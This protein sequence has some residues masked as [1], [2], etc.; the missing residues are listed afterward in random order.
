MRGK[1]LVLFLIA[2]FCGFGLTAKEKINS[3]R[4]DVRAVSKSN[5]LTKLVLYYRLSQVEKEKT[6]S[7]DTVGRKIIQTWATYVQTDSI[8]D[9]ISIANR[10]YEMFRSENIAKAYLA[11]NTPIVFE[12]PMSNAIKTEHWTGI[13]TK[14]VQL[15]VV[16]DISYISQQKII[17]YKTRLALSQNTEYNRGTI[18]VLACVFLLPFIILIMAKTNDLDPDILYNNLKKKA[19]AK[20]RVWRYGL[21]IVHF[22]YLLA[23]ASG[24]VIM[25]V[26]LIFGIIGIIYLA[27]DF[28]LLFFAY[29]FIVIISFL[30][31]FFRKNKDVIAN[32]Y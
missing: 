27:T 6:S 5:N 26:I 18:F 16:G 31:Y 1:I 12:Q 15:L 25:V 23:I 32:A 11:P 4:I 14:E 22:F 13:Y 29:A 17:I 24:V 2:F 19:A 9:T 10:T 8:I 20:K 3:D 7:L 21:N 28:N 30:R